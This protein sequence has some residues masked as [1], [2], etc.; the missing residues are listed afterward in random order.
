VILEPTISLRRVEY[1]YSVYAYVW[2]DV[3]FTYTVFVCIATNISEVTCHL[4]IILVPG[5]SSLRHVVPLI[6][7]FYLIMFMLITVTCL[8]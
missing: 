3:N 1:Y 6:T 8:G 5:I 4:K 7:H 2:C